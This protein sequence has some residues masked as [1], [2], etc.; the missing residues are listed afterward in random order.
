MW[1]NH[2]K[3]ILVIVGTVLFSLSMAY[4][5]IWYIMVGQ[6]GLTYSDAARLFQGVGAFTAILAGGVLAYR[7][8]QIFRTFEPHLTVTHDM[9]H[10]QIGESFT[11]IAVTSHLSNNSKVKIELRDAYFSIQMVS[12]LTDDEV[13]GLYVDTFVD[14]TSPDIEWEMLERLERRWGRGELVI[15]PNESHQETAEFIIGAG[16]TAVLVYSYFYNSMQP[17]GAR[18]A[19]GWDATSVYDLIDLPTELGHSQSDVES[20]GGGSHA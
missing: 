5:S 3:D 4:L 17:K 20:E 19:Q 16:V 8:L 12:P 14:K 6:L 1:R 7:R 18:S 2:V 11:H 13:V 15:E 9:S 10:R